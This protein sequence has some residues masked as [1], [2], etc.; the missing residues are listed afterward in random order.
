[1]IMLAG[2]LLNLARVAQNLSLAFTT[3]ENSL[4][5]HQLLDAAEMAASGTAMGRY[6]EKSVMTYVLELRKRLSK[7]MGGGQGGLEQTG[8]E[9]LDDGELNALVAQNLEAEKITFDA[10]QSHDNGT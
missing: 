7:R 1:M 8:S 2:D 5:L 6:D 10:S 9:D 4:G 3:A